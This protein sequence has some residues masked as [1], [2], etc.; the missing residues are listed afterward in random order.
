MDTQVYQ[1]ADEQVQP[2]VR[3]G[4]GG[5]TRFQPGVSGNPL[6]GASLK[7]RLA[8]EVAALTADFRRVHDRE[9]T[10]YERTS[11]TNAARLI[12]RLRRPCSAED[13]AKMANTVRRLLRG[14]GLDK[15]PPSP[16]PDFN[17]RVARLGATP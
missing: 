2:Q 6:G 14:L 10:H 7:Q 9:P 5:A 1:Q 4:R 13:M 16:G 17:A 15:P 12:I 11:M 3:T 8:A